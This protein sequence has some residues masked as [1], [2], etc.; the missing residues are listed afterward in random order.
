MA[1]SPGPFATRRLPKSTLWQVAS[2]LD[3]RQDRSASLT[4]AR[5]DKPEMSYIRQLIELSYV[6]RHRHAYFHLSDC[7]WWN[8]S[9]ISVAGSGRAIK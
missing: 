9:T 8:S 1:E 6:S 5:S 7:G 4:S 3:Q 2:R